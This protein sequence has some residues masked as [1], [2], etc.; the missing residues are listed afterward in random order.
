MLAL[1]HLECSSDA[2]NAIVGFLCRQPLERELHRLVLLR[3]EVVAPEQTQTISMRSL[4]K[5][6]QDS[7]AWGVDLHLPQAELSVASGIA[8]PVCERLHP[9]AEP[10]PLDHKLGERGSRH[11]CGWCEAE[12]G[13]DVGAE[14]RGPPK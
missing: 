13:V 7:M 8:V 3:N 6:W 4:S 12:M 14:R 10:W 9:A 5:P 2:E 1:A 11:D